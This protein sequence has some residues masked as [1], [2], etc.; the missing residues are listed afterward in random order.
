V[1]SLKSLKANKQ[2]CFVKVI[3]MRGRLCWALDENILRK[4]YLKDYKTIREIAKHFRVSTLKVSYYLKKYNIRRVERWERHGLKHFTTRQREYLFGSVLGD[5]CL[6]KPKDGKYPALQVT[7]STKQRGYIEWKYHLWKPIVPGGIKRDITIKTAKGVYHADGFRTAA[8][9][10]FMEFYDMFYQD[11]R[12]VVN[13]E[14]LRNLTPFSLAVWY[15][16]DG[17]Y[18]KHRGRARLSTNSFTY[19]ENLMIKK[20]FGDTWNISPNIGKS[21]SGTRYI[22]FNTENTLKFFNIIKNHILSVFGYKVDLKRK[23]MWRAYSEDEL[24]YIKK[25]YNVEHPRLIAY[26]LGRPLQFLML[27]TSWE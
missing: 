13:N 5:D 10:G 15:M 7:H 24:S 27:H 8:H 11:G 19:E 9:P 23:L 4:M 18:N 21:D 25:N 1:I 12:K 16:D 26:K 22:W 20:Y 17:H 14:I 6:R 2:A 3:I